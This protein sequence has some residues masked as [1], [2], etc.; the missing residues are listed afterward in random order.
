MTRRALMRTFPYIVLF[1]DLADEIVV[2]GVMHA[3]RDPDR[4]ERRTW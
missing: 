2:L 3:S 4:F 1:R